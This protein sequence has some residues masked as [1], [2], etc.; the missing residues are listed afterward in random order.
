[1]PNQQQIVYIES[2]Q[3][4][5]KEIPLANIKDKLVN[6][7]TGKPYKGMILEG[8]FADLNDNPNNNRR[9]YDIPEYLSHLEKLKREIHGPRGVYGEC[10]HPQRY[11]VDYNYVSHKI[12]DVWYVPDEKRVYGRLMLLNTPKGQQVQEIIK[13]GGRIAVSARAAGEAN[14]QPDGTIRATVKLLTTYDIVYH[15]GFSNAVM[16]FVELNESQKFLTDLGNKKQGFSLILYPNEIKN[17]NEMYKQYVSL[18]DL[19][20]SE[21]VERQSKCFLEH[22]ASTLNPFRGYDNLLESEQEEEKDEQI[23]EKNDPVDEDEKEQEL[24]KSVEKEYDNLAQNYIRQIQRFQSKTY[25]IKPK[26]ISKLK[27]DKYSV[28]DGNIFDGSAGFVASNET[29]VNTLE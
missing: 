4:A 9:I 14:E 1:M 23:L 7:V 24:S 8:I 25:G 20:E 12:L 26:K 19:S 17:L 16:N 10:E 22:L 2:P 3:Q 21:S 11:S 27:K 15:P 18:K 5:L 6:P 28:I 29:S 13:S